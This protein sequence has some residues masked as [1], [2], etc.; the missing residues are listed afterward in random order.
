M[1]INSYT[2]PDILQI[3]KTSAQESEAFMPRFKTLKPREMALTAVMTATTAAVTMVIS[4]PFPPTRGYLNLG[5][6]IVMLSGLLFGARV[7]GFA[8]GVGSALSD[9]LLG[10][11]YFAPLTLFIKGTEGFVT[12]LIGNTKRLSMKAAGVAVGAVAMLL[13]YFSVEAPLYGVGPA[14]AE[15]SLVNSVQVSVGAVVSL[16]LAQAILR[17]YPDIQFL[18][19]KR[20]GKMASVIAVI[21]AAVFLA[22]IVGIYLTTNISP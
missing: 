6:V 5:D 7:G 13:G 20:E 16:A 9:V 19:P 22:T 10:Y 18:K 11:G 17:T 1:G 14:F 8:G 15:L 3:G 12:G 4:I 21:I 2:L